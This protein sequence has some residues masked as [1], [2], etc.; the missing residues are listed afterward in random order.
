MLSAAINR[1]EKIKKKELT[2]DEYEWA[3]DEG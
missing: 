3:T 2:A 1:I